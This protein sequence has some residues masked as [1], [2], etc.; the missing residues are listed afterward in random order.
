MFSTSDPTIHATSTS[1]SVEGRAGSHTTPSDQQLS[2]GKFSVSQ[3]STSDTV[4]S[5]MSRLS[6]A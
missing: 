2:V 6:T 1:V 5:V 3:R 4:A